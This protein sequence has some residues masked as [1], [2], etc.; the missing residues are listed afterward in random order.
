MLIVCMHGVCSRYLLRRRFSPPVLTNP[1][2]AAPSSPSLCRWLARAAPE[3]NVSL[4][5]VKSRFPLGRDKT[6][7]LAVRF[8]IPPV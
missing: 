3:A 5:T 4:R 1:L 6:R 7:C 2:A 8:L